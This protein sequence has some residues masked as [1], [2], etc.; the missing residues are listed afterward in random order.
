MDNLSKNVFGG[1][2]LG[3]KNGKL[4]RYYTG[5]YDD[6]TYKKMIYGYSGIDDE[7]PQYQQFVD[8]GTPKEVALR[9]TKDLVDS[10]PE[11]YYLDGGTLPEITVKPDPNSMSTALL[12]TYYP[13]SRDYPVTGHSTL[14][15]LHHNDDDFESASGGFVT[16]YG[17]DPWYNFVTNNCSDATREAIEYA[18][19][20]KINPIFFTTPGDVKDFVESNLGGKSEYDRRGFSETVFNIPTKSARKIIEYARKQFAIRYK[21]K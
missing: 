9:W 13:W 19:G 4:P 10:Y 16:A 8:K 2:R 1:K 17:S 5:K 14:Q 21:K 3:F 15:L 11:V 20:K 7:R 18:T 12:T 6:D